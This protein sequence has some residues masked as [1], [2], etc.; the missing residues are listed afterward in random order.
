MLLVATVILTQKGGGVSSQYELEKTVQDNVRNIEVDGLEF[1]GLSTMTE[2]G[3]WLEGGFLQTLEPDDNGRVF[4]NTY[5]EVIGAVR[6]EVVRIDPTSCPW[7]VDG[8]ERMYRLTRPYIQ[9][10]GDFEQE[11]GESRTACFPDWSPATAS[12]APY[13]PWYDPTRYT[14]IHVGEE[15]RYIIDLTRDPEYA[16]RRLREAIESGFVDIRSTRKVR[17]RMLLYNNALPMLCNLVIEASLSPTGVLRPVFRSKSYAVQEYM[18]H[19]MNSIM[20]LEIIFLAWT[21]LQALKEVG[22]IVQETREDGIMGFVLHFTSGFNLLDFTRFIFVGVAIWLRFRMT[23]SA[24][25]DFAIGAQAFVDTE[26]VASLAGRYDL[27]TAVITLWSLF[28]TVQYFELMEKTA[29]LKGTLYR[30]VVEL[31]PFMAVFMLFYGVYSLVGNYLLGPSI[32]MYS[33]IPSAMY[34]SFDMMNANIPFEDL[35]PAIPT[36]DL[37]KEVCIV[38]Y[39][40]SFIALHFFMLLNVI[41]AIVVDAYI[42]VVNGN[43]EIVNRTLKNNMGGLYAD[44]CSSAWKMISSLAGKKHEKWSDSQWIDAIEK[45]LADR[46]RRGVPSVGTSL[47]TFAKD[48]KNLKAAPKKRGVTVPEE[49]QQFEKDV[50]A[51]KTVF[52]SG[53]SALVTELKEDDPILIQVVDHFYKR[54]GFIEPANL[55]DALNNNAQPVREKWQDFILERIAEQIHNLERKSIMLENTVAAMNSMVGQVKT[56]QKQAIQRMSKVRLSK[57]RSTSANGGRPS[58]EEYESQAEEEVAAAEQVAVEEQPEARSGRRRKSSSKSRERSASK[59]EEPST[60]E[61]VPVT[62][63]TA[64]DDPEMIR[65]SL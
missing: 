25:R 52:E 4:I 31:I 14:S 28:S 37:L 43:K 58:K 12:V 51:S 59:S 1:E 13:G 60:S 55:R 29:T 7:K 50:K 19:N 11:S 64:D 6:L 42:E 53:I 33:T 48:I 35:R 47:S 40:Y 46:R 3:Q 41:I 63:S 15:D 54:E 32:E 57:R 10:N 49:G 26:E 20:A 21:L 17:L 2:F 8:Y 39:Y 27:V 18:T 5:N 22:E 23:Q 30:A 61:S 44:I 34:T 24:A 9:E 45:V 36:G 56:S 16:A 38:L 65:K 62:S